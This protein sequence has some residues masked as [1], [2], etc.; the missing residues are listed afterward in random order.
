MKGYVSRIMHWRSVGSR[1]A[2]QNWSSSACQW[3]EDLH[4]LQ[5][6]CHQP[7]TLPNT[8]RPGRK[9]HR[10]KGDITLSAHGTVFASPCRQFTQLASTSFRKGRRLNRSSMESSLWAPVDARWSQ[11]LSLFASGVQDNGTEVLVTGTLESRK[12]SF[13]KG[14]DGVC[15][16]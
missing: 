11:P 12:W 2:Q 16:E 8:R 9:S 15:V 3:S 6:R 4:T 5:P 13:S 1:R 7:R 10:A 14:N